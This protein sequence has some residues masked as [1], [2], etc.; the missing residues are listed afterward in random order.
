MPPFTSQPEGFSSGTLEL[1]DDALTR[2]WLEQVAIGATMSGLEPD[3]V[4]RLFQ[5]GPSRSSVSR[6]PQRRKA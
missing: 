4:E 5:A 3:A 2:L 1:L 6:A